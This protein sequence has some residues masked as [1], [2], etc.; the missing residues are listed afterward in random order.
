[1]TTLQN[2]V[3]KKIKSNKKLKVRKFI[4]RFSC[5]FVKCLWLKQKPLISELEK[6]KGLPIMVKR[7]ICQLLF[8][9]KIICL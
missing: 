3:V 5:F 2:I 7:R 6:I 1:M 8:K 4:V 9:I